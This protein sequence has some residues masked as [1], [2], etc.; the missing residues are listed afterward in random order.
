MVDGGIVEFERVIAK[1]LNLRYSWLGFRLVRVFAGLRVGGARRSCAVAAPFG[2]S[3]EG[4][5]SE[6][7]PSEPAFFACLETGEAA[8]FGQSRCQNEE[9]WEVEHWGENKVEWEL[10]SRGMSRVTYLPQP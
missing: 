9:K 1:D 6:E 2:D 7:L 10:S 5:E 3:M 4:G 8:V